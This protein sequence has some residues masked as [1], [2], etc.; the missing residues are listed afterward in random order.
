[1]KTTKA[2]IQAAIQTGRDDYKAG[3]PCS[4][5]QRAAS[6]EK[7]ADAWDKGNRDAKLEEYTFA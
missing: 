2:D 7:I 1:M 6:D 4:I 3:R 5:T